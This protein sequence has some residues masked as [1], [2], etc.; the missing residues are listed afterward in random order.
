MGSLLGVVVGNGAADEVLAEN[1]SKVVLA[2]GELPPNLLHLFVNQLDGKVLKTLLNLLVLSKDRLE[3]AEAAKD[4]A[5]HEG[6]RLLLEALEEGQQSRCRAVASKGEIR[7]RT[8]NGNLVLGAKLVELG[9]ELGQARGGIGDS[10]ETSGVA[11]ELIEV[12]VNVEDGVLLLVQ[13]EGSD[14]TLALL[15]N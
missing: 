12:A 2:L 4:L 5:P 3:V 11:V 15:A 7:S 1:T 13:G 14:A 10:V 8:N 9:A 6:V